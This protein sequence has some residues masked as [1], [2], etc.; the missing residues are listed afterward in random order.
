MN[1]QY[2]LFFDGCSKGN[3]GISGSGSVIFEEDEEVWRH[4]YFVGYNCTNNIAEYNGLINGLIYALNNQIN[5]L[6]IYGDSKL[7]V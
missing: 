5:N 4:S 2:T 7:I 3:P 1:K 6:K